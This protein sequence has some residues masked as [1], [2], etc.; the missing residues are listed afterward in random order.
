[1]DR[2][3]LEGITPNVHIYN[4]A[5]SA[6]ARCSLWEKGYELFKEMEEAKIAHDVVSYNAVL[7]AVAT[8]IPLGR[9]LFE[10]GVQKGYYA[11]VSRLGTQWFEL[12]LHFLSLGGGEI[13][14]GWWFGE[15]LPGTSL[16]CDYVL[17]GF[18]FFFE[19]RI[20]WCPI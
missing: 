15:L 10:E 8:N 18:F 17:T 19:Q 4:S 13:A 12:D 1:M 11:R 5:I 7:D 2:M 20:A 14:L 9:K 6:C 16:N 3:K